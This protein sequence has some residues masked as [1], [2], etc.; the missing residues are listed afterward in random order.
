M[1]A[2]IKKA[3]RGFTHIDI[4]IAIAI[5][6]IAILGTSVYQY[7]AELNAH[8][9]DVQATAVRTAAMLCVGWTGEDGV[10]TFN[11]VSAFTGDMSITA[12]TGPAT[13]SGFTTVGSYVF[14]IDNFYYYATLSYKDINTEVRALNVVISWDKTCHGVQGLPAAN[15]RY[16]MTTY[17]KKPT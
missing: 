1:R 16:Q 6:V 5:L 10:D 8:K 2:L 4:L 9:A 13:P 14:T 7:Q 12:G 3:G 17:V 11:P 15:A